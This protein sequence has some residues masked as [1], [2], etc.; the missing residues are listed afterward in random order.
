MAAY[1]VGVIGYGFIGKVHAYAHQTMRYYYSPP[2]CETELVGVC[3][4][5]PETAEAARVHGR[6]AFATTDANELINSDAIQ[7]VHI[8]T[9]NDSHAELILRALAAGKS[10]YCDKPLCLTEDEAR[11]I[12]RAAEQSRQPHQITFH[13]RF[14]PAVMRARQLVA[15][16]ALGRVFHFRGAYLHSG[17]TDRARPMSW[18]LD[19]DRSGGGAIY[20]LGAHIVDV[21]RWLVGEFTSVNSW[22]ETM[23]TERPTRAGSAETAPVSVDDIFIMMGRTAGGAIGT[24]EASRLA[25]GANDQLR[26]EIHGSDGALAFD[27]ESPNWLSYYDAREPEAPLGGNRGF[28]RIECVQRYPAPASW[29]GPKF[30]PGWLRFHVAS[31]H[32]FLTAL[33][34]GTKA[35]P[36]LVEGARTQLVLCAA[37]RSAASR[38]EEPVALLD[39]SA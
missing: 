38:S 31:L 37:R 28:T 25:T 17:Y 29:P 26:F 11:K 21:L 23:I 24:V 39:A 36:D 34:S 30:T 3:T 32:G 12:A 13:Y 15:E 8:C 6:F 10:V 35:E 14:V 27:L 1:G 33:A 4:S 5:R 7:I 22:L 19:A 20:D 2:P 18:R 16:G 9:P